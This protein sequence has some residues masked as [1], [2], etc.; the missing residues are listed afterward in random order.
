[1]RILLFCENKY[2]VDILQP[3]QTEAN[4][5]GN[6]DV[7][8][9]VHQEKI[10]DFPLKDS[11]KWTNSIQESY[12]FCPEAIYVPGNIVPYYLPG[13]KIQI[14]HG[15]AAE[16]K[17]HWVIRRYFDIYCT[18]GPYF[19][20]HFKALAKKYG[21]FSVV[22]TGW[23]RQD[24]IFAHRHNFDNERTELLQEHACERIVVYAPTFSPKLTSIPF[25]LNDL[26]KLADTRRVLIIMKLHPLTKTE[27]VEA[28][29]ALADSHKN[30][31]MVGEFALTKYLLM[32]DVVV[33][34]TSSAIYEALLM[35]KPVIT[36]N[37][38]SK[39]LYWK[40]ITDASQLCD[41]Y[42]D[43]FT[44]KE[45][46]DLR[47]WVINNYDPYLDGLCAHRM[48]DAARDFIAHNGVPR[49]RKLNLWRKYTSIKTFGKIKR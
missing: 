32:A 43:I 11:V 16:K 25:I 49:Q 40:N 29:R 17:D 24:Y 22:E 4:K 28:C 42:D 39:D 10:P 6:N 8:W 27:W 31:I 13:V 26:R 44:N 7:L 19:T 12:N 35:D 14:F 36:L 38:I 20:S 33:S 47:K 5:E 21:D 41:A 45:I 15:Y 18:Q 3:I 46:A 30:I 1:M 48:L 2:A 23:T 34:D 9:Y 37:A